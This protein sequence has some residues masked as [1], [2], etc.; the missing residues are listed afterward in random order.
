VRGR[1]PSSSSSL[2]ELISLAVSNADAR[3]HL[4]RMAKTDPVT[5]LLN[6]GAFHQRLAEEI[7]RS[8]RYGGDLTLALLDIDHFK[9]GQRSPRARRG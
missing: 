6:H 7:E 2:A 5:G 9:Q 1:R 4:A 8:A 3:E